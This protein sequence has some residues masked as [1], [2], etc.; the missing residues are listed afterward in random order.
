MTYTHKSSQHRALP[1]LSTTPHVHRSP[2]LPKSPFHCDRHT[3]ARALTDDAQQLLRVPVVALAVPIDVLEA[4]E[5]CGCT[6]VLLTRQDGSRL[7]APLA[8]FRGAQSFAVERGQYGRQR[9]L[10]LSAMAKSPEAAQPKAVQVGLFA[11]VTA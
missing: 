7:Y 5:R 11:E 4:A 10:P 3:L 6:L 2:L 9:A 1:H 8:A